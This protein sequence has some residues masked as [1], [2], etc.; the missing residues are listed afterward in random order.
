MKH[1]TACSSTRVW[2]SSAWALALLLVAASLVVS[3]VRGYAQAGNP[4]PK[5]LE[6]SNYRSS[7]RI[8]LLPEQ[9]DGR[10]IRLY[11]SALTTTKNV[12]LRWVARSEAGATRFRKTFKHPVEF[13]PT[14][15]MKSP[16]NQPSFYVAGRDNLVTAL[17]KWEFDTEYELR[18]ET[19]P[20]GGL[21]THFEPPSITPSYP[22]IDP[23]IKNICDMVVNK[24]SP[25][26]GETEELWVFEWESRNVY[27]TNPNTGR[28]E[29]RVSADQIGAYRSLNMSHHSKYGAVCVFQ[30]QPFFASNS[31]SP[32]KSEIDPFVVFDSN[33]DGT[34]DGSFHLPNDDSAQDHAL[35]TTGKFRDY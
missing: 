8:E 13:F 26:E 31:D 32:H 29:I 9:P 6:I 3:S 33:L 10:Y 16:S 24:W 1:R 30:Q 28:K 14:A 20:T 17:E 35:F 23:S 19:W 25:I 4:P 18:T 27:V 11:V 34:I 22:R 15:Y 2:G 5:E 7:Q 12:L 21:K